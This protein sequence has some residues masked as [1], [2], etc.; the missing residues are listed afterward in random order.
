MPGISSVGGFRYT[1]PVLPL[2]SIASR[3]KDDK[4]V[5]GERHLR[6]ICE[7]MNNGRLEPFRNI[8]ITANGRSELAWIY[9]P[10]EGPWSLDMRSAVIIPDEV[11]PEQEN[12]P[13]AGVPEF[14]TRHNLIEAVPI[15]TLQE[16]LHHANIQLTNATLKDLFD[17]FI[18]Y[19]TN[20]A[21]IVVS[22]TATADDDA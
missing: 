16:I 6:K 1:L 14:A 11:P 5:C 15:A 4:V 3:S 8:L 2:Q 18:F 19:Y 10:R 22:P 7:K 12:E 17:A 20:D 13:N 9:L 21:F